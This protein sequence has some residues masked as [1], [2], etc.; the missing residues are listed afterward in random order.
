MANQSN[1]SVEEWDLLRAAPTM[2]GMLVVVADPSGPI[3][4]MQE[5][6]AMAEMVLKE[7]KNGQSE[8]M[9]S[10]GADL[11]KSLH[12]PKFEQRDPEL[13]RGAAL[14]HLKS[15][16]G[17]LAAK[18]SATEAKE[19]KDFLYT[20]AKRVAEASKEGGFLGF[21]GTLVSKEEEQALKDIAAALS[22]VL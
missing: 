20:T 12:M 6:A 16:G 2:A 5:S 4:L 7:A 17:L 15:V 22:G 13:L 11:Q 14:D 8:L 21:G 18:A 3:G 1:F 19:I 9:Q 10:L